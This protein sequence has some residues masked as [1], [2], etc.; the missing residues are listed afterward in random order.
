MSP[1]LFKDNEASSYQRDML[2]FMRGICL[3]FTLLGIYLAFS[4][5]PVITS[6]LIIFGYLGLILNRAINKMFGMLDDG[7]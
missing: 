3:S 7:K 5:E 4:E 6:I 1:K 2:S